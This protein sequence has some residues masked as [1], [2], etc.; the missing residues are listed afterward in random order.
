LRTVT[1]DSDFHTFDD[2]NVTIFIVI[3][4]QTHF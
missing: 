4:V 2:I 3:N 1:D